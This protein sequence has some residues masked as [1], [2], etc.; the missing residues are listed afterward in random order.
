MTS[1]RPNDI[2]LD[3]ASGEDGRLGQTVS[4]RDIEPTTPRPGRPAISRSGSELHLR[5]L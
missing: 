2:R 1:V 5:T 3:S 4:Q